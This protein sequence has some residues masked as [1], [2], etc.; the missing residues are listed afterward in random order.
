MIICVFVSAFTSAVSALIGFGSWVNIG[1][2]P[3]SALL[4]LAAVSATVAVGS[5]EAFE[6]QGPSKPDS[7]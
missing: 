4:A 2:G 6:S 5:L 7:H 1:D 3:R